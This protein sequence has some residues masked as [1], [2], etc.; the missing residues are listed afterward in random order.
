MST[1]YEKYLLMFEK[2]AGGGSNMPA[3][4]SG[5]QN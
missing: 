1:P 2:P 5:M 4:A 3:P